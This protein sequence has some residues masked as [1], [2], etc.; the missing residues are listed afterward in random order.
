M[1]FAKKHELTAWTRFGEVVG[2]ADTDGQS[3]NFWPHN[4]RKIP[5]PCKC[6]LCE[7]T[8]YELNKRI[9]SWKRKCLRNCFSL[10][11]GA[12]I[13]CCKQKIEVENLVT[14][15]LS[16]IS[17]DINLVIWKDMVHL[18]GRP[19]KCWRVRCRHGDHLPQILFKK[20]KKW[21]K[22]GSIRCTEKIVT[23]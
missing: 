3:C 15:S 9:S 7:H 6:W 13:K 8:N 14:L 16:E 5:C 4:H 10:F 18:N 11:W 23:L 19:F 22:R 12:Q 1:K 21:R 17:T 2:F 20:L